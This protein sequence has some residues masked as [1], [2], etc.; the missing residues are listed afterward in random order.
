MARQNAVPKRKRN[1]E[2]TSGHLSYSMYE[3][4]EST[5]EPTVVYEPDNPAKPYNILGCQKLIVWFT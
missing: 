2:P 3:Y 4:P 5:V 1:E